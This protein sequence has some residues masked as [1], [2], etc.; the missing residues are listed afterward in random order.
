MWNPRRLTT[1]WAFTACYRDRF[2]FTLLTTR[3]LLRHSIKTEAVH[4]SE[5][6]VSYWTIYR[7]IPQGNTLNI[8]LP[9][10]N[11]VTP[12]VMLWRYFE[13]FESIQGPRLI[14][15]E[16]YSR[17]FPFIALTCHASGQWKGE[18][19]GS[20]PLC[21]KGDLAFR[22]WASLAFRILI[23]VFHSVFCF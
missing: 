22:F 3:G 7:H 8:I 20:F 2:T 18:R 10:R 6:S 17:P 13:N 16:K 23:S 1:L 5:T 14:K 4:S 19:I 11:M 9:I 21:Y 12:D 15:V